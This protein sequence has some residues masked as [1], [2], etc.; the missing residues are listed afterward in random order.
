[1]KTDKAGK[2]QF[3]RIW[4]DYKAGQLAGRYFS[5]DYY[6]LSDIQAITPEDLLFTESEGSFSYLVRGRFY[7]K[8][9]VFYDPTSVERLLI[10][11]TEMP[12]SL[13]LVSKRA[14]PQIETFREH[15][16]Q[17]G[18]SLQAE[19]LEMICRNNQTMQPEALEG[20]EFGQL[21]LGDWSDL[22]LLM[23]EL[24]PLAAN[25]SEDVLRKSISS[26]E[27]LCLRSLKRD[28]QLSCILWCQSVGQKD[29]LLSHV[30]TR[31]E[32]RQKGLAGYLFDRALAMQSNSRY[33]L[34]VNV[35]NPARR[36]YERKGFKSSNKYSQQWLRKEE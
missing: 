35:A 16:L 15:L 20:Y 21:T 27:W 11:E 22:Q 28:H 1:M 33:I 10:P 36:L 31:T 3:I 4:S 13:D 18:F 7:A 32:E 2:D 19:N 5:N 12:I 23:C 6:S 30:V 8:L 14:N 25:E 29:V 26:G 24:D 9:T 34:W 17:K